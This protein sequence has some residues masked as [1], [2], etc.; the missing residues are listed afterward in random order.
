VTDEPID[1][2]RALAESDPEALAQRIVERPTAY[3]IESLTMREIEVLQLIDAYLSIGEIAAVLHIP[4][5][6]VWRHAR[7]VYQKLRVVR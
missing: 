2:P 5:Q 7:S 3:P 6:T 4:S 1:G